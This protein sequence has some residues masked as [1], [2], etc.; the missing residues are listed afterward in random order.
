MPQPQATN[1]AVAFAELILSTTDGIT[2]NNTNKDTYITS[3]NLIKGAWSAAEYNS[4]TIMDGNNNYVNPFLTFNYTLPSGSDTSA[5]YF[6]MEMVNS[7]NIS[8]G[9]Y[10]SG[11]GTYKFNSGKIYGTNTD[12]TTFGDPT[13]VSNWAEV[14]DLVKAG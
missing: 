10:Y 13:D 14:C 4:S 12:P 9:S 2:I 5:V 1:Y 6:Y 7:T 8:G 3:F 11:S